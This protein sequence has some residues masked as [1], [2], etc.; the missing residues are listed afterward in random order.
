MFEQF[1][2]TD[3][4]Q[5]NLDWIVK[6]A[7]DF[8][9]QYTHIQDLITNGIGNIDQETQDKINELNTLATQLENSLNQLLA[10]NIQSFN[11]AADL[12]AQEAIESIPSDYT[13][14]S[15]RVLNLAEIAKE[16][17]SATATT[18]TV[19]FTD[20]TSELTS[21]VWRMNKIYPAGYVEK[22]NGKIA[23]SSTQDVLIVFCDPVTNI[24]T[25][26]FLFSGK[27]G[28][29][30]LPINVVMEKD[31]TIG[32]Y[33]LKLG[34]KSGTTQCYRNVTSTAHVGYDMTGTLQGN[35]DLAL[36]VIYK[37]IANRFVQAA[38]EDNEY[39]IILD[40]SSLDVF[41]NPLNTGFWWTDYQ[42]DSGYIDHVT[43]KGNQD[44]IGNNC[45]VMIL[46][47]TNNKVLFIDTSYKQSD[48]LRTV[49]PVNIY[50][51]HKVYIAIM[52]S[53]AGY[54]S[55]PPFR[56]FKRYEGTVPTIGE[57]LS[58]QWD[59]S[60]TYKF[61][62]EVTYRAMPKTEV[63]HCTTRKKMFISGDS[64]TAGH[65]Y[66]YNPI[67]EGIQYGDAIARTLGFDVTYGAQSGNGWIY[68]SGSNYAK[69]ITDNTDF[70]LYDVVLYA[71]GTNDFYHDM[72]LGDIDDA[73]SSQ[74]ICGSINY[75]LNKMFT[76]NPRIVVIL[77][78]PINRTYNNGYGYTTQNNAG[79]T[80]L[81][82]VNKIIELCKARGIEY[83]DNT[84]SPF[85]P[86]SL[87]GITTDGLHPNRV[88]YQILGAYLSA[89]VSG[90]IRPYYALTPGT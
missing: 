1:P 24:V 27:S 80:L 15:D 81:D 49:I 36:S 23:D 18:E 55:M 54:L 17:L 63:K 37:T 65:P 77:S 66:N 83:I 38:A 11:I 44:G 2:Y 75:C 6:I 19:D 61:G 34:F 35:Y 39:S 70:S 73:P 26:E 5:L 3:M 7:K 45:G 89:K 90:I 51:E 71:W 86:N 40:N 20:Y 4:H 22:I 12:K 43:I 56:N 21:G 85:N 67:V 72:P 58:Y 53:N 41:T 16:I 69:N 57:S 78:T 52:G 64:I 82:L 8:L 48:T 59:G 32:V 60:A 14:L 42:Y 25:N 68:T 50:T 28:N 46:D 13:E 84:C 79:Y 10:S 33:C 9:D 30:E 87:S 31:F 74:T 47:A 88:G 62:V 29:F 76:D